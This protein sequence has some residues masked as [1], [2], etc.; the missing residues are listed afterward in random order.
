MW[1]KC[2]YC[3]WKREEENVEV[4]KFDFCASE[5]S[6]DISFAFVKGEQRPIL[7]YSTSVAMEP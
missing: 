4:W 1:R 5:V 6:S 7:T 2:L 3:L